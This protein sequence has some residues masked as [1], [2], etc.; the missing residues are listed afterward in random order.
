MS[1]LTHR[2]HQIERDQPKLFRTFG[3]FTFIF[4]PF[5]SQYHV[6]NKSSLDTQWTRRPLNKF[7]LFRLVSFLYLA[8]MISVLEYDVWMNKSTFN[9]YWHLAKIYINSL[10]QFNSNFNELFF[11]LWPNRFNT[12]PFRWKSIHQLVH[13]KHI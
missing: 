12:V 10:L 4:W 13:I 9:V 6:N 5:K 1:L 2:Q 11:F 8:Q 3:F 7:L